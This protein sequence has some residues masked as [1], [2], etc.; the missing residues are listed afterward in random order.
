[1]AWAFY[2]T[3]DGCGKETDLEWYFCTFLYAKKYDTMKEGMTGIIMYNK[4]NT[5]PFRNHVVN[6]NNIIF[7]HFV[8]YGDGRPKVVAGYDAS[9]L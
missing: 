3:Y 2:E 7:S 8:S 4:R 6:V 5:S 9:Y 1:M